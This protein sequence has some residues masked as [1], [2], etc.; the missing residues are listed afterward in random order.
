[1]KKKERRREIAELFDVKLWTIASITAW[2][3]IHASKTWKI[4]DNTSP[5]AE[6]VVNTP[7]ITDKIPIPSVKLITQKTEWWA[8]VEY[9]NAIKNKWREKIKEYLLERT[10]T[11]ERAKMKVMCLP[12]KNWLEVKQIYLEIWFLPE[13]IIWFEKN[14][15]A[16]EEF[17]NNKP[18]WCKHEIRN[19]IDFLKE[20]Q[21]RFDLVSLDFLG[22]MS[23]KN[24]DI[25]RYLQVNDRFFVFSNMMAKR[26]WENMQKFLQWYDWITRNM[27]SSHPQEWTSVLQT[28]LW[29][30]KLIFNW[31]ENPRELKKVRD[32]SF[33]VVLQT[34]IWENSIKNYWNFLDRIKNIELK[35]PWLNYSIEMMI[36]VI[37]NQMEKSLIHHWI[38]D[39]NS[40]RVWVR[41]RWLFLRAIRNFVFITD[42]KKYK[43]LSKIWKT[44]TPFV[45]DFF[46]FKI[47][48]ELYSNTRYVIN[49]L[50]DCLEW[51]MQLEKNSQ[52]W[53]RDTVRFVIMDRN[54]SIIKRNR[55]VSSDKLVLLINEKNYTEIWFWKFKQCIEMY[56]EW[57][58]INLVDRLREKINDI[59][60]EEIII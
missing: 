51:F 55:M 25:F 24:L 1:M 18:K 50:I 37:L 10:T 12:W 21:D 28:A 22:P 30:G 57:Q 11:T 40:W 36:V 13:N 3:K 44:S 7:Q 59:P 19:I 39:G 60:R 31:Q 49:F 35:Y 32:E 16:F 6:R 15:T 26:E 17:L 33:L 56:E 5:I 4:V 8:H 2:T 43:Y 14:Q 48:N 27:H 20:T 45:S 58:K 42:Y 52:E 34:I 38:N 54:Y 46:E 47:P 41:L 29:F 23:E 53:M 9:N